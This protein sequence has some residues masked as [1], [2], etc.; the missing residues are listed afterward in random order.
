[1]LFSTQICSIRPFKASR[2]FLALARVIGPPWVQATPAGPVEEFAKLIVAGACRGD[3]Y[4]KYPSWYDIFLVYKV[5][6]PNVLT[7]TFRLLLTTG[8]TRSTSLMGIGRQTIEN[9]S[10]RSRYTPEVPSP[11]KLVLSSP[12]SSQVSPLLQYKI[13]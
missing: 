5:F 11:R 6:A 4:V 12:G 13:E 2:I 8:V 9:G 1:M 3:A 10:S 7:W